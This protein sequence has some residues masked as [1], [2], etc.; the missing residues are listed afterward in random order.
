[1]DFE[2][3]L[4]DCSEGSYGKNCGKNCSKGCMNGT[5]ETS[6]GNCTSGCISSYEGPKCDKKS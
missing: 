3:S 6:D 1:M 5:C 4:L 2:H